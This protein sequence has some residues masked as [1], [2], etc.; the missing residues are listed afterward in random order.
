[1]DVQIKKKKIS[2]GFLDKYCDLVTSDMTCSTVCLLS[3][4]HCCLYLS[5]EP[6][7]FPFRCGFRTDGQRNAGWSSSVLSA[8]G[9]MLFS[10]DHGGWGHWAADSTSLISL[11]LG[12]MA[13]MEVWE[14]KKTLLFIIPSPFK[15]TTNCPSYTAQKHIFQATLRQITNPLPHLEITKDSLSPYSPFSPS[16]SLTYFTT[17]SPIYPPIPSFLLIFLSVSFFPIKN[18]Y[19]RDC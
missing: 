15:H 8:P 16:P 2:A 6:S 11:A 19:H 1:M 7:L 9:A 17:P 12:D 14:R 13:T 3:L 18:M 5:L 10:E 4:L